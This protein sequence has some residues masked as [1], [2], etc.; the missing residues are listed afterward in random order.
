MVSKMVATTVTLIVRAAR[1]TP[2]SNS[3]AKNRPGKIKLRAASINTGGLV[4]LLLRLTPS[5]VPPTQDA[6]APACQPT[7]H[8]SREAGDTSY[9]FPKAVAKTSSVRP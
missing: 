9:S 3:K 2:D 4:K 7:Y 5:T 1:A 6:K 8:A